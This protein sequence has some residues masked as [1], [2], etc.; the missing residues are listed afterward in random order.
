MKN[1]KQ[2]SLPTGGELT[3]KEALVNLLIKLGECEREFQKQ[4][5]VLLDGGNSFVSYGDMVSRFYTGMG[6]CVAA[7]GFL[8]GEG[9]VKESD[10]GGIIVF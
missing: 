3:K 2:V 8:I 10:K 9:E 6:D 4:C 1:L 7:V 5:D